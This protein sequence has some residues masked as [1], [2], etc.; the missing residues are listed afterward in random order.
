MESNSTPSKRLDIYPLSKKRFLL[1]IP[2]IVGTISAG[3]PSPAND[4]LEER[5]D[6]NKA[7]IKNPN[8]TFCG[9]VSG[10]SMKD[11]GIE[12]DDILIIDKSLPI[13]NGRIVVCS[14]EGSH[15]LKRIVIKNND[16]WLISENEKFKPIKI[17]EDNE[18]DIWGTVTHVI[19]KV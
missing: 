6:L 12:E 18:F 4:Y 8:S 17:T 19:K 11:A 3:F 5:I 7:L 15:I 9:R 2:L 16:I 13:R 10:F 1:E 14:L